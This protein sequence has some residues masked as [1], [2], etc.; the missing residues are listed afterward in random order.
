MLLTIGDERVFRAIVRGEKTYEGRR[1]KEKYTDVRPGDIIVFLHEGQ[2]EFV[3]ARVTDV[4]RYDTVGDMVRELWRELVPFAESEEDALKLY[5]RY[6]SENDPA[7]AFGIEV[8]S[9]EQLDERTYRKWLGRVL[10][11]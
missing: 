6:Y 3:V 4:R 11:R 8:L 9:V 10:W 7:V 2:P 5:K 1:W